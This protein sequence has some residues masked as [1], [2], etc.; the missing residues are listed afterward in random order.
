MTFRLGILGGGLQGLEAATLARLEGW[1]T[2]LVDRT[3]QCP[4]AHL[5]NLFV[6][7]EVKTLQDLDAV[8][9]DVDLMLPANEKLQTLEL[10]SKWEVSGNAPP[11]AFDLASFKVSRDKL[12]SKRL[13][14]K[15]NVPTPKEFDPRAP[16]FP[17]IVKPKDKS[18]SAG[19]TLINNQ[20]ELSSYLKNIS[21]D[22]PGEF[23]KSYVMEEYLRGPSY[24]LEV[25]GRDECY[26]S[27][28]VTELEMD[29][30]YDCRGVIS[31]AE[32]S[33]IKEKAFRDIAI[34][35]AKGVKLK[36]LMDVE[37]IDSAS[38]ELQTLEIDARFPSQT[39]LAVYLSSGVNLLS[40]LAGIFTTVPP[41][42]DI[43][44]SIAHLFHLEVRRGQMSLVGE[45]RIS[46]A[47]PL[48]L[49]EDFFGADLALTDYA[50]GKDNFV[51]TLMFRG[52]SLGE[53]L[54]KREEFFARLNRL[55][56]RPKIF[57]Q[58]RGAS[59]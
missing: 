35:L 2:V 7:M 25:T 55:F 16:L 9:Q 39:P 42:K 14:R 54:Y 57:F 21:C 38:G 53:L 50:K 51:V 48:E 24:S 47:P 18:G 28:T 33:P 32:I 34:K 45:H 13:F 49:V 17:L 23:L 40:E 19:V 59:L 1:D 44:A 56:T 26:I 36:G 15:L 31:P 46:K 6:G 37:V 30:V 41:S 11:V 22:Y 27:H 43:K 58:S 52:D 20:R 10:V 4:A 29:S 8:F 3:A 5:A 12:R